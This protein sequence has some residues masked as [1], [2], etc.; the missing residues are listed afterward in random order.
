M[1]LVGILTKYNIET[2]STA[3]TDCRQVYCSGTVLRSCDLVVPMVILC[4]EALIQFFYEERGA[5]NY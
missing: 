5:Q 3:K 4:F 2:A 1:I